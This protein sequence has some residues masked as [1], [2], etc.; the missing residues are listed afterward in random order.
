MARKRPI[1]HFDSLDDIRLRKEQLADSMEADEKEIRLTWQYMNLK[2][3]STNLNDRISNAISYGVMAY[4]G[5]MTFRK[6]KDKFGSLRNIF[7]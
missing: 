4:D 2:E 3:E 6:L 7:K 5:I 1:R